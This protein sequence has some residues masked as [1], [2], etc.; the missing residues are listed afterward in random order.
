MAEFNQEYGPDEQ[1]QDG[2]T[3]ILTTSHPA[4][5]SFH[6]SPAVPHAAWALPLSVISFFL[7]SLVY[8]FQF[9]MSEDSICRMRH[10]DLIDLS[11]T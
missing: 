3:V 5:T 9:N 7:I 2:P 11:S 1:D 6:L 8:P 10:F 4:A